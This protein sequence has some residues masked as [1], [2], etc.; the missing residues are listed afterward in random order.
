[1]MLDVRYHLKVGLQQKNWTSQ[2]QGL[3]LYSYPHGKNATE[4]YKTIKH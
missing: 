3:I 4:G 2:L 1:M